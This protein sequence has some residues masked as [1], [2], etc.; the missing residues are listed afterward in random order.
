M[1]CLI[2]SPGNG[3]VR[4][5]RFRVENLEATGVSSVPLATCRQEV[6]SIGCGNFRNLTIRRNAPFRLSESLRARLCSAGGKP[7]VS[8]RN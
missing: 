2:I 5:S 1:K 3:V 8:P 7:S 4:V 6:E